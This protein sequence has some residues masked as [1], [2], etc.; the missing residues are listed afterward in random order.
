MFNRGGAMLPQKYLSVFVLTITLLLNCGIEDAGENIQIEK[1][2]NETLPANPDSCFMLEAYPSLDTLRK[3]PN[4]V[5]LLLYDINPIKDFSP[6]LEM[7][8]LRSLELEEY[9]LITVQP[10]GKVTWLNHLRLW[11]C[12]NLKDISDL[13]HITDL[14]SLWIDNCSLLTGIGPIGALT[15]LKQLYLEI[16]DS[17]IIDCTVLQKLRLKKLDLQFAR[18]TNHN[19]LLDM[20]DSG[21]LFWADPQ[22]P[23]SI[24][25]KL[26]DNNVTVVNG[27]R[28]I[29]DPWYSDAWPGCRGESDPRKI[30]PAPKFV[31]TWI[32]TLQSPLPLIDNIQVEVPIRN[33]TTYSINLRF[34]TGIDIYSENGRWS[35]KKDSIYLTA[36]SCMILDSTTGVLRQG[37]KKEYDHTTGLRLSIDGNRI[38]PIPVADFE[39]VVKAAGITGFAWD[40]FKNDILTLSK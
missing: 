36:T 18:V 23:D 1:T 26:I 6:L 3:H 20:L 10:I 9:E 4:E 13:E 40:L 5:C 17:T 31:G 39:V 7:H 34:E 30:I 28:P 2:I 32:D 11:N 35:Q 25:Q 15:K 27:F 22:L 24:R 12:W 29:C 19:A 38:W 14:Q 21:S 37:V 16:S 33:D 8:N